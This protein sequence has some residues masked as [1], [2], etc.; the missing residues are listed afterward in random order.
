MATT[1]ITPAELS[2]APTQQ[3][4]QKWG[5][6]NVYPSRETPLQG[7]LTRFYFCEFRGRTFSTPT[8]DCNNWREPG[9]NCPL[10]NL[11]ET[12][13]GEEG[14]GVPTHP[15]GTQS[16]VIKLCR[17]ICPSCGVP[18]SP[19]QMTRNR[20]SQPSETRLTTSPGF[21]WKARPPTRA[22]R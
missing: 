6:E 1:P 13:A 12:L 2:E 20:A 18:G 10:F 3:N 8:P 22:P 4:S 9:N 16:S 11:V 15:S 21:R 17:P 14:V 7:I 19:T 5:I